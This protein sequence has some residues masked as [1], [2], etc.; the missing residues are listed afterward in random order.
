M[1]K[2]LS[3]SVFAAIIAVAVVVL[4]FI[5][6]RMFGGGIS[7][8]GDKGNQTDPNQYAERMKGMSGGS[9][10]MMGG[11]AG[12]S[13]SGTAGGTAATPSTGK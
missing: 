13:T 12:G 11:S 8:K 3:P 1:K 5:G 2:Q 7:G 6:F 9:S 4:G 10:T